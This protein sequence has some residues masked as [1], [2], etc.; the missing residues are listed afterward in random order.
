MVDQ[1]KAIEGV[2][3]SRYLRAKK[4]TIVML[5]QVLALSLTSRNKGKEKV[6]T[7]Q[8]AND[9]QQTQ[10]IEEDRYNVVL[11][12]AIEEEKEKEM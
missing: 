11:K 2:G 5:F 7:R 10:S 9:Q 6:A 3:N 4:S 1:Q 8:K 12:L